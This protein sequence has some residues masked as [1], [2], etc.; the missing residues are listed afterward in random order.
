VSYT[1]S[2]RRSPFRSI[3]PLFLAFLI[4]ASAAVPLSAA[5]AEEPA[6]AEITEGSLTWGL[7][8][9]FREYVSVPNIHVSDGASKDGDGVLTFP[10]VSGTFD[11]ETGATTLQFSGSV[12]YLS[13]CGYFDGW[14]DD[15]CVLDVEITD[16][17]VVIDATEQVV[18]AK[19]ANRPGSGNT[20]LV[21]PV[22]DLG[23]M[24]IVT[25]NT[26]S[27]EVTTADGSTQWRHVP[28]ALTETAVPVFGFYA[29]GAQF[30]PITIDYVGPGGRPVLDE[31]WDAPGT[32]ALEESARWESTTSSSE[33]TDLYLDTSGDIVHLVN[34]AP[35][36]SA[37]VVQA[38]DSE[39]LQPIADTGDFASTALN[40]SVRGRAYDPATSTVFIHIPR[41]GGA[42]SID[43]IRWDGTGYVTSTVAELGSTTPSSGLVW[44]EHGDRLLAR[45]SVSG[46]E[47]ID[48]WTFDGAAWVRTTYEL[49]QVA[50]WRYLN[51]YQPGSPR[52]G[53][54]ALSDGSVLIA[55][56]SVLTEEVVDGVTKR[57]R[58]NEP[59]V[60]RIVL[61]DEVDV[62]RL[63][64]TGTDTPL[65]SGSATD[66]PMAIIVGGNRVAI[67]SRHPG[68]DGNYR[69]DVRLGSVTASGVEFPAAAVDLPIVVASSME[70]SGGFD[71]DDGTLWI[72]ENGS[73]RLLAIAPDGTTQGIVSH[74]D[75]VSN[76]ALV[77]ADDHAVFSATRN[78]AREPG[79][80]RLER[81]GFSPTVITQPVAAEAVI[82]AGETDDTATFT[83]SASGTPEPEVHWQKRSP[84]TLAFVDI[85][86]AT[87]RTATVGV[88]ADDNGAEYRA[89]FT[90]AAGAIATDVVVLSV[91]S[92]P[93]I[94]QQPQ[95]VTVTP[96]GTAY[97]QV[98]ASGTPEPDVLWQEHR[99][100]HWLA[101]SGPNRQ[102]DGYT[103]AVTDAS[104]PAQFRAV[105]SN[106][107][108]TVLST[109]AS[110]TVDLPDGGDDGSITGL[111]NTTGART[112]VTPGVGLPRNGGE[113]T[114]SGSGFVEGSNEAGAYVLFGYVTRFPS[115]A[116]SLG[117]GYDYVA[118]QDNQR[119]IGWP[120]GQ[121]SGSANG[122][123]DE[124]GAFSTAG[125]VVASSFAGASGA[126]VNCLDNSVECGVLTIGAHG[127]RDANLETFTPVYFEG[128][129]PDVTPKAPAISSSPVSV[130]V[131]VG[132]DAAFSAGATGWPIPTVQWQTRLAGAGD[133]V[134]VPG[135]TASTYR[136]V[137]ASLGASGTQYRAVFTNSEGTVTSDAATL[138]VS[139]APAPT[140]T[141]A[142]SLTWGIKASFRSYIAGPVAKG[143]IS[144][145]GGVSSSGSGFRFGQSN[146]DWNVDAGT[147][148]ADYAGSVRFSG[149][150][151]VLDLT[152]S[153]PS[154]TVTS[155]T[156]A[157]LNV[158]ANGRRVA[159]GNVNLA[160]AAKSE[161]TGGVGYAQAPVTLT[162][163]GVGVFSYGSS[164][165]YGVGTPM[166]PVSFVIGAA[167]TGGGSTVAA[168]FTATDWTP[169]ATPPATEGIQ[170]DPAMLADVRV[171][172]ELSVWA[173]GF[174]PNEESIKVVIYSEPTVLELNMVADANGRARWSGIIP[175]T[176]EPGEHT[177]TFQGSVN[178][179]IV[180]TVKAAAELEGC[181]VE[182]ATLSWG[183]KESFR[184]YIEGSIA[185]GEWT[186]TDGATYNDMAFGWANGAG[187]YDTESAEGQVDFAG[188]V[189]FTGHDGLL[190][191][192]IANPSLQFVND[193]TA[194]LLLD[195]TGVT[196][197][198]AMAGRTDAA[199]LAQDVA[200]V[201]LDLSSG[202][203]Q[204]SEDGTILTGIDV[205]AELTTQ[206]K[207]AFPNYE[208]GT[209][210]DPVS[211]S[212]P[213]QDDCVVV[214][215]PA[216]GDTMVTTAPV[217][218][219]GPSLIWLWWAAGGVLLAAILIV[220]FVLLRRRRRRA[221]DVT[222]S[223][224]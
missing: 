191:T 164:Q 108:G 49:P 126:S 130:N 63:E 150:S 104:Q 59:S 42:S 165:F 127:G 103:L 184:S 141:A 34:T 10:L 216:D 176:V 30:D 74:P 100:G 77:V 187:L 29:P 175:A 51:Y 203:V 143:S 133:W 172:G 192:T 189:L 33:I 26:L 50:G 137:Q 43:A 113:V 16:P 202:T 159:I 153:N 80:A 190:N 78:A 118:G 174:T 171:G 72:K 90:N 20:R 47:Y 170:A 183:F 201:K 97:F 70:L 18:R 157:T 99:E 223:T 41:S 178:R 75:S 121:T 66:V 147:G 151:G 45:M 180:L 19:V 158:T 119:F 94:S 22:T 155:P 188:T 222:A 146:A 132:Q 5:R 166:D 134:D 220:V 210:F 93:T 205:P 3:A 167:S 181:S 67:L 48:A 200:F 161:V 138:T 144:L 62:E 204:L 69:Y 102:V 84:G 8:Q 124:S 125:L 156:A 79:L 149:H 71:P 148:S 68:T 140:A 24:D 111:P 154:I 57:Q 211:F 53:M 106:A 27:G 131:T 60:L 9:S 107:H 221:D 120:G 116:G 169:P 213:I 13:Y 101:V 215:P 160:A 117:S 92:A 152:L 89:V 65:A 6:L 64:S 15:E 217:A 185:H 208:A 46:V 168:A 186:V 17:Q 139:K 85:P 23:V 128:Q 173:D 122:L 58:V 114:V 87:S 194:Y 163:A 193:T 177:L 112:T 123:F 145:S 14:A 11:A 32:V 36:V 56:Q 1:A 182:G 88:R 206:G 54:V 4:M 214:V 38:L 129:S 98:V 95:N 52:Y 86:D 2:H 110:L 209:A 179:G 142:G 81:L 25:L 39:T 55:R 207:E 37:P 197:E 76:T 91:L 35:A 199:V 218:A 219:D 83:A 198:D 31:S 136:V 82:E 12:H 61:G 96:G 21:P 7:R 28:T 73:G 162:A 135:A 212:I 196:M 115:S 40:S 109:V 44:D 105:V 224:E 195:V